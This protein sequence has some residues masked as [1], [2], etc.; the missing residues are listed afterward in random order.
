MRLDRLSIE[1]TNACQKGCAF[2]YNGSQ[3]GGGSR[4]TVGELLSLIDNCA[5]RG[6]KAVSFGGGEPL[7]FPGLCD[8][9]HRTR[10]TVFRSL[11]TH[12]LQLEAHLERLV[13]AAPDKVHISIHHPDRSAEVQRVS[14][15]V[16]ALHR[17]GVRAGV[18]LLVRKSGVD[19][20]RE[21]TSTLRSDGIGL[22][23]IVFLP[24]RGRDTPTPRELAEVAGGRHF[25]S[26]T[27]LL[28][29]GPS[30]RFASIA[31]DRTVAWC[32]Y[33]T[34]R[35][36]LPSLD[37]DGLMGALDGLGLAPCSPQKA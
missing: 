24:M 8:L 1:L 32:S 19:A 18:N 25:Q 3:P 16:R 11:T 21:C 7:R 34:R 15:Q 10:G 6:I 20:A 23:R 22:D 2:C 36:P 9:L 26:M 14:R 28:A 33:T 30:P 4:W 31:W 5:A 13:A 37:Y 29:C 27:C 12:G 17:R 35:R